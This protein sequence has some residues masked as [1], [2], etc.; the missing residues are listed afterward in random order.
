MPPIISV[1]GKSS[2]GKTTLLQGVIAELKRRGVRVAVVKHS[3][4]DFKLD[5]PGK[6]TWLL[7]QAGSELVA[8][9]SPQ[10]LVYFRKMEQGASLDDISRLLGEDFDILLT[11]GF[12]K[13]KAPKIEVHRH[14]QGHDLISPVEELIAVASDEP[15]EVSLPS[16]AL[17]DFKGL[18]DLIEHRIKAKRGDIAISLFVDGK[19]IP[20]GPFAKE[21]VAKTLLGMVSSLKGATEASSK[22]DISIRMKETKEVTHG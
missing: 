1:V 13:E 5:S 9:N 11:E 14:H 19:S 16:Y 7:A 6:D 17:D 2:S 10:S 18:A 22:V 4:H 15:L 21:I 20:L 3:V 12:A 8:F